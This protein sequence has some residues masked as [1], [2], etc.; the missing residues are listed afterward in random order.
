MNLEG[1][2]G[3]T[4][5]NSGTEGYEIDLVEDR[6]IASL[7]DDKLAHRPL[8]Q[9]V[10]LLAQT[11]STPTTIG[12]FGPWGSG[13]SSLLGMIQA[14]L[15]SSKTP[16]VRLD[17][18]KYAET[19][20]ARQFIFETAEQLSLATKRWLPKRIRLS[21]GR[22]ARAKTAARLYDSRRKRRLSLRAAPQILLVPILFGIVIFGFIIAATVIKEQA[23]RLAVE[24]LLAPALLAGALT[25]VTAFVLTGL[26]VESE[27]SRP[28]SEEEFEDTFRAVTRKAIKKEARIV[29]LI[30]ELDRC[31]PSEVMSTL[32]TIRTFLDVEGCIFIVAGDRQ[33]IEDALRTA[34]LHGAP[35][36]PRTAYYAMAGSFLDKIFQIQIDIPPLNEERLTEFVIKLLQDQRGIWASPELDLD[37]LV[38]ILI[39]SHVRSPRRAKVLLNA[40]VL[41]L[42]QARTRFALEPK[43]ALNPVGKELAIAKLVVLRTEFPLFAEELSESPRLIQAMTEYLVARES[44]EGLSDSEEGEEEHDAEQILQAFPEVVQKLV[45]DFTEN[46]R[47][48]EPDLPSATERAAQSSGIRLNGP[49]QTQGRSDL[50]ERR[51]KE[52]L[53][54]LTSTAD[55]P[56]PDRDVIFGTTIGQIYNLDPEVALAIEAGALDGRRREV[57]EVLEILDPSQQ[58]SAIKLLCD[59]SVKPGLQSRR[60]MEALMVGLRR[61]VTA[62]LQDSGSHLARALAAYTRKNTLPD[63]WG[64]TLLAISQWLPGDF[65]QQLQLDFLQRHAWKES[66]A[67]VSAFFESAAGGRKKASQ[68]YPKPSP[69][70]WATTLVRCS[71]PSSTSILSSWTGCGTMSAGPLWI[72][73]ILPP[74]ARTSS[75]LQGDWQKRIGQARGVQSPIFS[76]KTN[77]RWPFG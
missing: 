37:E 60:A 8:A 35:P 76:T 55:T 29:F 69:N 36:S 7:S 68:L 38:P 12:L 27:S 1:P 72:R 53:R 17:A 32:E 48:V 47:Q 3:G 15:I 33:V 56:N 75:Q 25:A 77:R 61:S 42:R 11:V 18:W 51:T 40:F 59:L 52:L 28:G 71:R 45:R 16:V 13:K 14:S 34:P 5:T 21:R 23:W 50:Q 63:E 10:T 31:S 26:T 6:A 41:A 70:C 74:R 65:K 2:E 58:G 43:K 44:S 49:A 73:A 39:P 4:T 22:K 20:L 24:P 46:R 64:P 30:D 9:E 62:D 66:E 67:E 57:D 19:P 54:Y